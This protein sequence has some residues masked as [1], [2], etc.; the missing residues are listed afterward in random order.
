MSEIIRWAIALI[1][2]A[3]LWGMA[4]FLIYAQAPGWGWFLTC[5]TVTM[6]CTSI[7]IDSKND[8]KGDE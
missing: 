2:M 6:L 1:F 4:A 3:S 5:I 7:K 8:T